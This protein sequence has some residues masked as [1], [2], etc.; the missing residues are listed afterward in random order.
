MSTLIALY[1]KLKLPSTQIHFLFGLFINRLGDSLFTLAIPWISFHLTGSVK[2][3]GSLYVMSV[4]PVVLFGPFIGVAVD[5]WN[6]R[7]IMLITDLIRMVI[8]GLIPILYFCELLQLW[9]L[10]VAGFIL[11]IL[12][13]LFDVATVSSIPDLVKKELTRANSGYQLVNQL[14]NLLGP[15]IA[16]VTIALIGGFNTLW[17]NSISFLATFIIVWKFPRTSH[18]NPIKKHIFKETSEG[19]K[20]LVNNKLNFSLSLQ[21]MIGNFGGSAVLAIFMYYLLSDLHLSSEMSGINYTLIGVGGLLGS[22]IIVPLERKVRRG[23][24]I[25]SLLAIGAFGLLFVLISDFW[26]APGIAFGIATCCNVGWNSIVSTVRQ[27]T[28]PKE[29]LGR[30]LGFSRMFT[31]LAM[32]LGAFVGTL[33]AEINPLTVFIFASITKFVEVIIATISPIKKL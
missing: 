13:L 22:L 9:Q 31:R 30:V 17:I 16:G 7:M 32:P 11:A 21:A 5:R 27:E 8:V 3:M 6:K 14:A 1:V 18:E 20:W 33:L 15:A 23:L 28:V 29:M 25:Q 12:T 24:L 10:Y 4:L 26:L 19:F 2:I